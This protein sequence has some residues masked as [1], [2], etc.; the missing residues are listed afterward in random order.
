MNTVEGYKVIV[1]TNDDHHKRGAWLGA[2]PD[3]R[4]IVSLVLENGDNLALLAEVPE[5]TAYRSIAHTVQ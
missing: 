3:E 1:E 2:K 5:V 4:V